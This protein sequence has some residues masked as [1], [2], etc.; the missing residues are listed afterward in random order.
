MCIGNGSGNRNRE[1]TV[2]AFSI[3]ILTMTTI[4]NA[5]TKCAKNSE[6]S[7]PTDEANIRNENCVYCSADLQTDHKFQ[8]NANEGNE[9]KRVKQTIFSYFFFASRFFFLQVVVVFF[10]LVRLVDLLTQYYW[11]MATSTKKKCT[12]VLLNCSLVYSHW[13]AVFSPVRFYFVA[14]LA[15]SFM[16]NNDFGLKRFTSFWDDMWPMYPHKKQLLTHNV[17]KS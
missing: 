3:H 6:Y 14:A 11:R 15:K 2:W 10:S 8:R 4:K 1:H 16:R 9:M 12:N 5:T 17:R 7:K 13:R